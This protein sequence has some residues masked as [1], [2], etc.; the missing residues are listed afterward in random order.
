M[1]LFYKNAGIQKIQ[2]MEKYGHFADRKRSAKEFAI[3]RQSAKKPR[4]N[5]LCNLGAP[6]GRMVSLPTARSRQ[7]SEQ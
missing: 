1:Y 3:L 4:V 7:R 5:K 2:K 6:A